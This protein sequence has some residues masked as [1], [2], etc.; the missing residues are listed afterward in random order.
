MTPMMAA[1]LLL[2]APALKD[3]RKP[4][5]LHLG[6]WAVERL[7]FNG[8]AIEPTT[9]LSLWIT[10]DSVTLLRNGLRTS[11]ESAAFFEA[12]RG[13]AEVDFYPGDAKKQRM[14]IWKLEENTLTICE[15]GRGVDRP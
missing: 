8:H 7:E 11:S 14:G 13:K 12:I 2:S 6:E 9:G 3:M 1:A 5:R 4:T 10:A 15:A